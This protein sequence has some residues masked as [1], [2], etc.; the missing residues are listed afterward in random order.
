MTWRCCRFDDDFLI[1]VLESLWVK[2]PSKNVLAAVA[3]VLVD[4][5]VDEWNFL[6]PCG[7]FHCHLHH[8]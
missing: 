4:D 7:G 3:E 6:A 8:L 5:V 1:S 2:L